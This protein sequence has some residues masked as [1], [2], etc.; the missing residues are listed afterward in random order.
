MML[1]TYKILSLMLDYPGE[2]L[3]S[4]LPF[5]KEEIEKEG[6]LFFPLQEELDCFL[7]A[8]FSLTLGEWQMMYVRHFDCSNTV[9]LYMLNHL[10]GDSEQR[11]E[12]MIDL[13]K[14]Y[15]RSGLSAASGE[16]PDYLPLFL[17][18]I[19]HASS[20]EKA[21]ELL[22]Y[23]HPVLKKIQEG[24]E[25]NANFYQHLFAILTGLAENKRLVETCR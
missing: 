4:A 11:E 8:C 24:L 5:V 19:A 7:S 10:Y 6:I 13:K 25:E 15:A 9:N 16:L 22:R 21:R 2:E 17:E 14:M 20:V 12:A 1:K 3:M 18:Y 23:V